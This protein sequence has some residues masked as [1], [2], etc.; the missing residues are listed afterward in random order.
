MKLRILLLFFACQ[1]SLSAQH[2]AAPNVSTFTIAA[3]QLNAKKKIWVYLPLNY[4]RTTKKY[5][6]IYMQD[7]QNLFDAAT[8]YSGEWRID[9]SLN[10][11]YA[12]VI[13][14]GIEHGE[15]KRIEELAPFQHSQYGTGR[16]DLYLDFIIETLKPHIDVVYRTLNTKENTV[17]MG[18]SLGGL[19]SF[20]AA[21]KY[22]TIFG[23]AG[24]FSPSFWFSDEIFKMVQQL[25][26][27]PEVKF[28]FATGG[29]E[30]E[31]TIRNQ[32]KMIALLKEKGLPDNRLYSAIVKGK[33][34]NELFWS[35]VFPQAYKWLVPPRSRR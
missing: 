30:E 22:P 24:I 25:N 13:V 26:A 20:Y 17:I 27:A 31:A 9:E 8:A 11:S 29:Q 33:E 5:P 7:A 21:I 18:S 14:V 19:L 1:L 35:E 2:T 12:E 4:S 28:Y 34:H 32:E 3:P 23:K 15:E 16:G 10:A 6:V